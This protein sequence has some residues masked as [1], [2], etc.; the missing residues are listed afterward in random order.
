P[1]MLSRRIAQRAPRHLCSPP[2]RRPSPR[3]PPPAP[4]PP[5]PAPRTPPPAPR[6][7]VLSRPVRVPVITFVRNLPQVVA[8]ACDREDLLP[9]VARGGER[10]VPAVRRKGRALVRP[11]A[12]G[13]PRALAFRERIDLDVEPG[14]R[15]RRIPD[16]VERL[17]RPRRPIAPRFARQLT[18]ARAVRVHEPDLR[19]AGPIRRPRDLGARGV[20]RRRRVDGRAI[21]QP[22]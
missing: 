6:T 21:R 2:P 16:L 18:L 3:P 13:H 10:D 11:D 9:A 20:P 4:R 12:V 17:R 8:I 5:P 14:A 22:T 1:A 15:A 19:V 7:P